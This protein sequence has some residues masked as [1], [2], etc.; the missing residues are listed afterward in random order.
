M[1]RSLYRKVRA[2]LLHHLIPMSRAIIFDQDK[3]GVEVVGFFQ[4]AS[5]IGESAR[6][7]ALQLH[8][9][10]MKVRCTS[11]E[12]MFMKPAEID[13]Q[14]QNTAAV[15]E[16]GC[17]IIHLNP[18]MMPLMAIR[19]G[20]RT[21]ARIYNIGYWAW[22]LEK[23][24]AE[25][26]R[27][28]RY[29]NAIFCPSE[30]T[31]QTIR[32]YTGK[33][34]ET[35]PH[36]VTVGEGRP[37]MRNRLGL[38]DQAFVVSSLFS[39]GSALERKNPYAAVDAFVA[40]F[41]GAEDAWLVLKS[42]HGGNSVEKKRFLEYIKPY[43]SIRLIDDIWEKDEVLGLIKASDVYLS[44]HRSE[45]FGLPIAEAMLTGTPTVVTDWSGSR[46]FCNYNNSFPVPY[47]LIQVKSSHPEFAGLDNV[48]W[49]DP[50]SAAASVILKK[51][52]GERE[53]ARAKANLCLLETNSYF[54]E[55]RYI[56]ALDKL[57]INEILDS[58]YFP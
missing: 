35:V 30:F 46:D 19:I 42:N 38:S 18:P 33:P 23:I 40:A 27:A 58:R 4:S 11:V 1:L 13:W 52:Y 6:L 32:K 45:G 9:T 49:A 55:P 31:S 43:R 54:S 3:R 17:R 22:E 15:D 44:L 7:C 53:I 8:N 16:I 36:P 24:P 20:L 28:T 56:L 29:V 39:F 2:R 41:S 12:K 26:T 21:F 14:F 25:W 37:G 10:G 48:E 51:I 50:D 47:T 34:V 57:K 5:G